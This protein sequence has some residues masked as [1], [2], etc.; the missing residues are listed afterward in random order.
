MLVSSSTCVIKVV[1]TAVVK[2]SSCLLS[3]Y[4]SS[5]SPKFFIFSSLSSSLSFSSSSF[6]YSSTLFASNF[7]P[8]SSSL[9][10][11]SG[12]LSRLF[13]L[14][15]FSETVFSK[16][17]FFSSS[18]YTWSVCGKPSSSCIPMIVSSSFSIFTLFFSSGSS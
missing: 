17:F 1:S 7:S 2:V 16:E 6:F 8:S 9:F 12:T 18:I 4:D 3:V 10:S 14:S 5:T 13:S 15:N 11:I